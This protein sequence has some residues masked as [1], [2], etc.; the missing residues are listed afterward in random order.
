MTYR[1]ISSHEN[2]WKTKNKI[3]VT[4][5]KEIPLNVLK[6][7]Y[8]K[9]QVPKEKLKKPLNETFTREILWEYQ[10]VS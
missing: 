4:Y 9:L 1:V 10:P 8:D 2:S 3:G 7:Y 5:K 6:I